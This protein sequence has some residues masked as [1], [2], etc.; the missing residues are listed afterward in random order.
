MTPIAQLKN[1]LDKAHENL[2]SFAVALLAANDNRIIIREE[3][4]LENSSPSRDDNNATRT[5]SPFYI[6]ELM[7]EG[8]KVKVCQSHNGQS[9]DFNGSFDLIEKEHILTKAAYCAENPAKTEFFPITS[10]ARE[11]VKV[12]GFEA[13]DV[14]DD[15]M[16]LLAKKMSSAYVCDSYWIDLKII[17]EEIGFSK[18][19]EEE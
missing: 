12:A 6:E 8:G 4:L 16:D 1:V 2:N 18:K 9:V 14:D 13:D 19:E 3:I 15:Q 17:A 7:Y 10:V 5:Y 11:D